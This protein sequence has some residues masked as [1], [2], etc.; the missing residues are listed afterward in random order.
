MHDYKISALLNLA[1]PFREAGRTFGEAV[2]A[3]GIGNKVHDAVSYKAAGIPEDFIFL[4]DPE[5]NLR[6]GY[7]HCYIYIYAQL[8]TDR[9]KP[10]GRIGPGHLTRTRTDARDFEDPLTRSDPTRPV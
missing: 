1:R 4:I 6:V 10:R 7:N 9:V 3:A 2:F 5:S 8:F